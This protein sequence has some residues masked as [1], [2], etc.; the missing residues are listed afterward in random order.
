MACASPLHTVHDR[1]SD[2]DL[3][4]MLDFFQQEK[5][6]Q[7]DDALLPSSSDSGDGGKP[8]GTGEQSGTSSPI[9]SPSAPASY[10]AG[11]PVQRTLM[12]TTGSQCGA[13]LVQASNGGYLLAVPPQPDYT[14]MQ[15]AAMQQSSGRGGYQ[16]RS[17]NRRPLFRSDSRSWAIHTLWV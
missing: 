10:G 14:A 9:A 2:G 17:K 6:F 8:P 7:T 3:H 15:Q 12:P 4:D 13:F 16:A 5:A 11:P 1:F